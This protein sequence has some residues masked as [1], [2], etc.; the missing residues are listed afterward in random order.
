MSTRCAAEAVLATSD[1]SL[2]AGLCRQTLELFR[3]IEKLPVL[4]FKQ[5]LASNAGRGRPSTKL[6]GLLA[7]MAKN[8]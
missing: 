6:W 7:A 3:A 5:R 1:A 8:K 2:C 4:I